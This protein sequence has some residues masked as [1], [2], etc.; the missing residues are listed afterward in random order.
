M[1]YVRF[2]NIS[3]SYGDNPVLKNFSLSLDDSQIMCLVG[4]SGC[5]KTTL[6]RCLLGLNRPDQG[7]IYVGDTCVFSSKKRINVPAERRGIGIVFQDYA[8]WPHLTVRENIA[9]PLRK[10]RMGKAE[11]DRRVKRVLNQVDMSEYINHLPSQLS[12]GQQQRVAIARALMTSDSLIVL[13]EPITNLDAKL[14]EQMLFEIRELQRNLGTTIFYITHDQ[15][16][17]LQ[18]G[19]QIAIMDFAGNLR[20]IGT[21]EDIIL[22]PES[23]FIF[24]F[25]G[26]TNFVPLTFEGTDCFLDMGS[27]KFP[28][29]AEIPSDLDRSHPMEIGLRPNDIVFDDT[30]PIRAIVR[31]SVFLGSEYDYF[32]QA[33]D[34]ELRVQQ[35]TLDATLAGV[36]KEGSEVGLTFLNPHY[37]EATSK[38]VLTNAKS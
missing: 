29:Q 3:F 25:I 14:R 19:D 8:V 31:R 18:L 37:Y 22:R 24:E 38:E 35:S 23:R 30:S 1:A 36:A 7:E 17:A 2:E 16:A 10:R 20:Q 15:R 11:I 12:G 4:P 9:Y 32:L 6:V 26:V 33:G 13:D 34:V 5:G 27:Q 28:W 21:D